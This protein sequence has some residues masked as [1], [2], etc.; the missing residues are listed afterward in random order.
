MSKIKENAIIMQVFK[1]LDKVEGETENGFWQRQQVI[2]NSLENH[3]KKLCLTLTGEKTKL[4]EHLKKGMI[5]QFNMEAQS[6]EYAD[7]KWATDLRC[8]N[9]E[10][11]QFNAAEAAELQQE[12]KK[13]EAE[14]T[15]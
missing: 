4:A 5:V 15:K 9:I 7:G 1:I 14:K 8:S 6:R 11:L 12:V 3:E 13:Q 10:P 2:V